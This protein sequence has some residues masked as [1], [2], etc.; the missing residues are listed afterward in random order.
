MVLRVQRSNAGARRPLGTERSTLG[1]PRRLISASSSVE[2]SPRSP[3][4]FPYVTGDE[5]LVVTDGPKPDEVEKAWVE[6][7][8]EAAAAVEEL[9]PRDRKTP[10]KT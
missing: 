5:V 7:V 2:P 9:D 6:Q 1:W 10:L 8:E 4:F 3:R